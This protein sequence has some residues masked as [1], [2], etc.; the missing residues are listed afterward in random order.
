MEYSLE[1]PMLKLQYFGHL[2][3]R[4]DSLEQT[5]IV[6][7]TRQESSTH[8]HEL[9]QTLGDS[10][11]LLCCHPRGHKES[12]TIERLNNHHPRYKVRIKQHI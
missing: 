12:D 6:G 11:G 9:E 4:G 2:M 10:E 8:G 5:L 3:Q 7:K 1:G